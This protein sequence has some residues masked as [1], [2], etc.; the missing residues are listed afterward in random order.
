M[1]E[2]IYRRL[3]GLS[4]ATVSMQL[5][6]RGLRAVF[7]GGIAPLTP[8]QP[9]IA[10]PAYTLRFLPFREDLFDAARIGDPGSHQRRA[11][12]EAPAGSVMV[13]ETGGVTTAAI[14]GDILAARLKARGVAGLVTDGVVRDADGVRQTGFPVV[15]AGAAAPASYNGFV[16]GAREVP[17]ACGGVTVVPGDAIVADGDG[18]VVI[19]AALVAEVVAA[20]EEQEKLEAWIA[21]Q[22]ANG[23]SIVGLY[24]PNAETKARYER[25][26]EKD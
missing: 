6:K 12:E 13:V 24:P 23:R 26:R 14:L 25:E 19:P 11:I 10:G 15:C 5:L 9:R 17:V 2:D 18:A 20:G 21:R 1:T 3:A 22:A 16:D 4:T 7:I 8:S